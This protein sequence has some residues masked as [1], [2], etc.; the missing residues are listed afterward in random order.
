M[1]RGLELLYALEGDHVMHM[2]YSDH[3][4]H[5]VIM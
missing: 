3:V 5:T 1:M 2:E 4:M